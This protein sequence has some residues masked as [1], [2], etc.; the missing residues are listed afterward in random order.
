MRS[1]SAVAS[2]SSRWSGSSTPS[3]EGIAQPLLPSYHS[4]HQ[5]SRIDRVRPPLSAGFMPEVPPAPDASRGG[6]APAVVAVVP[7]VPPA[8]EDR[9]VQAAVERGLHAGGAAGLV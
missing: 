1:Y 5:P 7:L 9:Q 6:D 4:S 2:R 3:A 8:V